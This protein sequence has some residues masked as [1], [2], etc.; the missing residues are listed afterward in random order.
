MHYPVTLTTNCATFTS[1]HCVV[2]AQLAAA[3]HGR[4]SP[5]SRFGATR[6]MAE[7]SGMR[8]GMTR[9]EAE[10]AV[11][12]CIV[13]LLEHHFQEPAQLFEASPAWL[14]ACAKNFLID[15]RRRQSRVDALL[16]AAAE[17]VDLAAARSPEQTL[18]SLELGE[19]ILDAAE[20]LSERYHALFLARFVEERAIAEI[21]EAAGCGNGAARQAV[22]QMLKRLRAEL[23]RRGMAP[24]HPAATT[25]TAGRRSVVT[26][27]RS[28]E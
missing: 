12:E 9:E 17:R 1:I 2:P 7:A 5:A 21:A 13:R 24:R 8:A 26:D 14:M 28:D 25:G 20:S 11:S 19:Q 16:A 6:A 4:M 23:E 3:P 27:K 10:D 22:S 15:V 18:F